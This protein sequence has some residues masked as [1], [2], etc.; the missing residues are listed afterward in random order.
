MRYPYHILVLEDHPLQCAHVCDMLEQA[1][2]AQV[3][4]T[5]SGTDAL[6]RV[7][8]TSYDL[9]LLDLNMPDMDGMQF[10]QELAEHYP[11]ILI[12]ITSACSPRMMDSAS[13]MARNMNLTVID[14]YAKPFTALNAQSLGQALEQHSHRP[15][16][17]APAL[18]AESLPAMT[19]AMLDAALLTHQI[20][21]W[22]QPKC[23]LRTGKIVGVEALARWRHPDVG[24]V[25]PG[26]FLPAIT[27]HGKDHAL[28]IHMLSGALQA[29]RRWATQGWRIPVS[30]N[31]PTHLLDDATLPDQLHAHVIACGVPAEDVTF[32]LLESSQ[33]V[34]PGLFFMGAGRLRLKGFGL[35]QDDF[36]I[37]YSSMHSLT[38]VP[39]TELKIDRA[40]ISGAA[41]TDTL[42]AATITAIMLGKELGMK[43]TAEGVESAEDLEFLRNA[44]CDYVQGFLIARP[45]PESE[46]TALLDRELCPS[47]T[48]HMH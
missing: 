43:V 15:A 48:T 47:S 44:G 16:A 19:S 25:S 17:T 38:A 42:A 22:F 13:H 46:L 18:P 27:E 11:D 7:G 3:D 1:G 8:H 31:L 14:C 6:S 34:D 40:F 32:E 26:V 21:P 39:F 20:E 41:V 5:H 28:L 37:G 36:G 9:I 12:A 10:I 33:T 45:A 2:F 23:S 30:V 29:Y 24:L 35:A 4:T